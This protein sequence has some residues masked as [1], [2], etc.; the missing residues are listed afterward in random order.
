MKAALAILLLSIL[1]YPA[2]TTEKAGPAPGSLEEYNSGIIRSRYETFESWKTHVTGFLGHRFQVVKELQTE[3]YFFIVLRDEGAFIICDLPRKAN[4]HRP[5]FESLVKKVDGS[6]PVVGWEEAK[7]HY[8]SIELFDEIGR[9][10]GN[11]GWVSSYY[12]HG[13]LLH[14]QKDTETGDVII[15]FPTL[16]LELR[17]GDQPASGR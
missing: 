17:L 6:D 9:K 16:K 7:Q 4:L 5:S 11:G 2:S 3:D 15:K 8:D 12:Y 14:V 1:A 13:T 10:N